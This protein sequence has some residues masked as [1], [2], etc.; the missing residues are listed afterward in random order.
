MKHVVQAQ[1]LM[2]LRIPWRSDVVLLCFF[3]ILSFVLTGCEATS[4]NSKTVGSTQDATIRVEP[5]LSSNARNISI[6]PLLPPGGDTRPAKPGETGRSRTAEGLPLLESKGIRAEDLF[7]EP[8]KDTDQRLK[9]LENAVVEIRQDLDAALPAINRLISIEGDIQELVTQLQTLMNDGNGANNAPTI[10]P[11]NASSPEN[12]ID[13]IEGQSIEPLTSEQLD[14]EKSVPLK[15]IPPPKIFDKNH[16]ASTPASIEPLAGDPGK[17]LTPPAPPR[18]ASVPVSLRPDQKP[19][20]LSDLIDIDAIRIGSH[21]DKTRIVIDSASPIDLKTDLDTDENILMLDIIGS[22]AVKGTKKLGSTGS[23]KSY[24]LSVSGE[25]DSRLVFE[26]NGTTKIIRSSVMP[27]T[28]DHPNY[29][30]IIDLE[31]PKENT[32]TQKGAAK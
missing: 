17:M 18:S 1:K 29:R 10:L 20:K 13:A 8:I 4:D 22:K 28:P 14:I 19:E 21:A 9:R 32:K 7:R 3:L 31:L 16:P 12:L 15:D 24:S 27:P 11:P 30:A 23:V 5:D 2:T 6:D 25:K 26:L